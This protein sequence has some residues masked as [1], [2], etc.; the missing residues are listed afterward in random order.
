MTSSV[1]GLVSGLSTSSLI[2]QLLK[3]EAQPQNRLKTKVSDA[4]TAVTSYMSVNTKI[5][6][7]KSA[8]GGLSQ[9]DTWRSIKAASSSATVTATTSST[10]KAT[11]GS[12]TFDVT[13]LASKQATTMQVSTAL[14]DADGD[15]QVD[16][17][18]PLTNA[19]SISITKGSYDSNGTFTAGAA[20]ATS[21]DISK[22][23]SA[24][25]IAQAINDANLGISAYVMKTDDGVGV[26]QI[27]GMKSGAANGFQIDG[28]TGTGLNGDSPATTAPKDATLQLKGGNNTSYAVH[29]DTN[30]FNNLMG[31]VTVV[32][33]KEETG[34]T[35]DATSDVDAIADK[36]SAFVDAT[37]AALTEIGT[38]TKYDPATKTGSPLTGDFAVRN[39][40]QKLLSLVSSGLSW[41]DEAAANPGT[42]YSTSIK[43]LKELG[44]EL[45]GATGQ[46]K[47]NR[48]AFL[49]SYAEDPSRVKAAGMKFGD[50]VTTLGTT[51]TRNLSAIM[52]GRNNDITDL[53]TQISN[54]DVR[55]TAKQE[56]LQKQYSALEVALGKLKDQ[57]SWLSGQLGGAS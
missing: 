48:G 15:G 56:A 23:Q 34:V 11:T 28:L 26:L 54:W 19:T 5:A 36:F 53:N 44:I 1:D 6:A 9:L 32:V 2:S 12:L 43:S 13:S 55:L 51:M 49:G 38:Q 25:G 46:L 50:Q 17:P 21:I 3:V 7:V 35:V 22:D 8:G 30:T 27:T 40:S 29:S 39:M 57:S 24:A 33:S 4:Q 52:N 41:T 47:F 42:D 20:A 18:H 14:E 45:D 16:D 10:M 37:N 31:G